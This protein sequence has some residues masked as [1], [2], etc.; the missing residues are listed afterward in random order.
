MTC[1]PSVSQAAALAAFGS[2]GE[3]VRREIVEIFRQ[4]RSLMAD[5][6]SKIDNVRF[7]LPDGAFYFF[8]NVSRFGSCVDIARRILVRRKVVT[9][10]GAAFGPSGEGYLRLS[11]AASDEDIR[12][13]VRA[14]G[15]ELRG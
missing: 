4:R 14:I 5:E 8:V 1:A 10:P 12:R 6:L 9:I 15:E 11:F 3:A 13:G 7:E 2:E